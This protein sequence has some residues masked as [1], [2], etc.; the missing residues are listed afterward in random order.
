MQ[1][2]QNDINVPQYPSQ[3][4]PQFSS[5]ADRYRMNVQ[6]ALAADVGQ[7]ERQTGL[8]E[9]GG[10]AFLSYDKV[11]RGFSEARLAN[12]E[13]KFWEYVSN[14]Q[15]A[16]A[17]R[18]QGRDVIAQ[19]IKKGRDVRNIPGTRF[20]ERQKAGIKGVFGKD[21]PG[22]TWWQEGFGS[23]EEKKTA[24]EL[25]NKAISDEKSFLK[26]Q[27][28]E[29][30][31][32]RDIRYAG[33]KTPTKEFYESEL[34]KK[35]EKYYSEDALRATKK[36][37]EDFKKYNLELQKKSAETTPAFQDAS[38]KRIEE[39][40]DNYKFDK[41]TESELLGIPMGDYQTDEFN[42]GQWS[43][44]KP[45]GG[46]V[47]GAGSYST[48]PLATQTQKKDALSETYKAHA[49]RGISQ[50]PTKGKTRDNLSLNQ[51]FT[52]DRKPAVVTQA[53]KVETVKAGGASIAPE[54]VKDIG[55]TVAKIGGEGATQV[56]IDM[57]MQEAQKRLALKDTL[58]KAGKVVSGV[59]Y[60]VSAVSGAKKAVHGDTRQERV[61][62]AVQTAGGIAG[63]L[64][65]TNAWNPVGWAA[66]IPAALS[67]G[68]GMYS[69]TGNKRMT[70]LEMRRRRLG[71]G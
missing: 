39:I 65:A 59:G 57:A 71:L 31:K 18:K 11:L 32:A 40:L 47:L 54:P 45:G 37:K 9:G 62:G 63:V 6:D 33:G 66:A 52:L 20:A 53:Q 22:E 8:L 17:Y 13:L 14:P 19:A 28:A 48:S 35:R 42:A 34:K 21:E 7:K 30:K 70:P 29:V 60:G 55:Q 24:K 25:A 36:A 44:V 3:I 38:K 2:G 27:S 68:G 15:I 12:P 64:A 61:G 41:V 51:E 1:R 50:I 10:K 69:A 58:G 26:N 5:L 16:S 46:R 67:I 56:E 49:E 43:A 4:G 23:K